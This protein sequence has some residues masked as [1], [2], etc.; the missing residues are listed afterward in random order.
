MN[1]HLQLLVAS[2]FALATA[3]AYA[4]YS[5]TPESTSPKSQP[6]TQAQQTTQADRDYET[7]K[8]ACQTE[9]ST[10]ARNECLRRAEDAYKRAMGTIDAP[11]SGGAGPAGGGA[12]SARQRS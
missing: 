10:K 3:G 4:Q 8:S 6:T 1:K 7:A 5:P 9:R 11:V 2:T 12:N